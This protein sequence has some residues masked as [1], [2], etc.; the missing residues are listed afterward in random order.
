VQPQPG[1]SPR[2]PLVSPFQLAGN[3]PTA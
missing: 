1:R 3:C 2:R